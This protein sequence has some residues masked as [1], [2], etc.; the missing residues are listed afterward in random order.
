MYVMMR[1]FYVDDEKRTVEK[2]GYDVKLRVSQGDVSELV[3]KLWYIAD[4]VFQS[5]YDVR[6]ISFYLL[7]SDENQVP[8]P[9][10][11][12]AEFNSWI[13]ETV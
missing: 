5:Q 6:L 7:A 10:Q 11:K 1:K 8:G 12:V 13:Y 9:M 4:E 3:K 2:V